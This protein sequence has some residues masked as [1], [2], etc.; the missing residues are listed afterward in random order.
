MIHVLVSGVIMA[1]IVSS[2]MG[3]MLM[4]FGL[5]TR[6]HNASAVKKDNEGALSRMLINWNETGQVCSWPPAAGFTCTGTPG[7][8]GCTCSAGNM[9]TVIARP[10]P[11]N[12]NYCRIE[13]SKSIP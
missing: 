5:T 13:I 10:D 2:M 11:G 4:H 8:C 9:P 6:S 3:L 1:F 7:T 12:A